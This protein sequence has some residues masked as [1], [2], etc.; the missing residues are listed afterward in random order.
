MSSKVFSSFAQMS[1]LPFARRRTNCRGIF[2][3]RLAQL[4]VSGDKL[5]WPEGEALIRSGPLLAFLEF[6]PVARDDEFHLEVSDINEIA[7]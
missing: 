4:I 2:L 6:S 5:K 7:R 3:G 1:Q